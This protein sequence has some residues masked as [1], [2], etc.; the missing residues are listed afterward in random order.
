MPAIRTRE[1]RERDDLRMRGCHVDLVDAVSDILDAMELLGWPMFVTS[2]V[3][4]VAQ[5]QALF[6]QGRTTI[7][8]IVTNADGLIKLSN[9]QV[10]SDGKGHAVD[11]AFI[12]DPDTLKPEIFDPGMPW[13]LMGLMAEKRGLVW[14]GRW[15][16]L[17]DL[18]HVELR[19]V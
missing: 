15:S 8:R 6:A 11:L 4:T 17:V 1:H 18:P 5:Q 19:L 14:G 7:G 10:K 9:H 16:G 3:R 2:G 12:D 13:D